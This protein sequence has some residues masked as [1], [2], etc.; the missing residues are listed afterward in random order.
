VAGLTG[1]GNSSWPP[2]SV[3]TAALSLGARVRDAR[4]TA[5][6]DDPPARAEGPRGPDGAAAGG[7]DH[8]GGA[9]RESPAAQARQPRRRGP[10]WGAVADTV[11]NR[12]HG[13]HRLTCP[14]SFTY[15]GDQ[16][17][18]QAASGAIRYDITCDP[19]RDRWY[20]DASWTASP[21]PAA[22][23]DELRASPVVA[24]D[25][26]VG[27][28][29]VAVVTADGNVL[30][31]PA[32]VPLDLAGLPAATRDGRLRAAISNLIATARQHGARAVV[33]E[34]LDFAEARSEGRERHA[35]LA[36]HHPAGW[37][38][39]LPGVVRHRRADHG[40]QG[41]GADGRRPVG[42]RGEHA[43]RDPDQPRPRDGPHLRRAQRGREDR[44][45]ERRQRAD[46]PVGREHRSHT[47]TTA[48]S[49]STRTTT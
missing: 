39:D 49:W 47:C 38:P 9:G 14:V 41:P 8:V 29:A 25:V 7:G 35:N 20:I 44:S 5:H 48:T 32:T 40:H 26:N 42:G 1:T 21:A 46:L 30:G 45:R 6:E 4:R 43:S 13:R 18:A 19:V 33:I 31:A 11:A 28:L 3:R 24:V 12:P 22:A 17:A 37:R 15:R 36:Q 34:D 23:L 2:C 27:H 10:D 16:V